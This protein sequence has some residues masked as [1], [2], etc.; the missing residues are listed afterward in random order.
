MRK[1]FTLIELLVVIAILSILAALLFPAVG[2]AIESARRSNCRNNVRQIGLALKQYAMDHEGWYVLKGATPAYSGGYLT[3]EYPFRNHVLRLAS[4]SYI[5]ATSVW[6]CPSD[7]KDGAGGTYQVVDP[8]TF[9]YTTYDTRRN[10]SYMYVAGFSDS[11]AE[12]STSAPVL[13]DESN[14]IENGAATPDAMPDITAGDNHGADFRNVLYLDGH[15]N[16]LESSDA[17]NAIFDGMLKPELLQ[18]VD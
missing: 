16:A 9:N 4:N 8:K 7:K 17:A 5:V 2:T 10:C 18:S 1:G 12:V 15:V 13:A 6:I 14:E 11:S 3:G